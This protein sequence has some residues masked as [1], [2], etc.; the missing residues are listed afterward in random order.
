MFLPMTDI[1]VSVCD[2]DFS[3]LPENVIKEKRRM[4]E[5]NGNYRGYD[6]I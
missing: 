6:I 1:L 2:P 4:V 3:E 5:S